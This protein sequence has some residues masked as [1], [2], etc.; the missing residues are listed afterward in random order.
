MVVAADGDHAIPRGQESRPARAIAESSGCPAEQTAG[1]TVPQGEVARG[2]DQCEPPAVRGPLQRPV[3]PTSSWQSD[4]ASAPGEVVDDGL[5]SPIFHLRA[6]SQWLDPL[7]HRERAAIRREPG[8]RFVHGSIGRFQRPGGTIP[9]V[10]GEHAS[11]VVRGEEL[12]AVSR[13]RHRAR[14]GLVIRMHRDPR[15]PPEDGPVRSTPSHPRAGSCRHGWWSP[16]CGRRVRTPRTRFDPYVRGAR[17][18]RIASRGPRS[19]ATPRSS[20]TARVRPSGANA[21]VKLRAGVGPSSATCV[22][23]VVVS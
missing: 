22:F 16:A 14:P 12:R 10:A 13:E 11:G 20:P 7:T 19:E 3:V 18:D 9:Q 21:R 5:E 2:F 4:R 1:D 23:P 6:G 15:Q 17:P 8:A